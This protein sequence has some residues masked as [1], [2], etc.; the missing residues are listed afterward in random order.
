MATLECDGTAIYFETEGSG[1]PVLLIHGLGLD[2][3]MWDDQVPALRDIARVIRYDARGFGRSPRRDRDVPYTHADDAWAL[4]DHVGA[5]G[6]VLVGQSMG[7]RIAVEAA[8]S[9]PAR[10]AALVLIDSVLEG[11]PWDEQTDR[12]MA[13][14]EVA[15]RAGGVPA[16]NAAW[17]E[18]GFFVPARRDPVVAARLADMVADFPGLHWHEPDPHGPKP[19]AIRMLATI[20]APTTVIV[21]E[22]DVPGFREM[23]DVL[24]AGLPGARLVVVSAAGHMTN[25]EAPETVNQVLREAVFAASGERR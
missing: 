24:A 25:L 17:L 19:D 8:L 22:L 21:G 5:D 11:V 12:E 10:V 2:A 20:R 23:S 18:T 1:T 4:L 16:A 3:R 7:G 14:I 15:M 13:A 6:V 9:R